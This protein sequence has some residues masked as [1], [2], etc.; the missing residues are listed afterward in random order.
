MRKPTFLRTIFKTVGSLASKLPH[1]S[2]VRNSLIVMSGSALAQV[3]GYA[4]SIII[5]RLYTPAEF[6]V[7]GAFSA[8]LGV[9]A[10]GITLDY[11]LAIML[12]KEKKRRLTIS[13]CCRPWRP[14]GSR[15]SLSLYA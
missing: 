6:G 15:W 8:V 2:F 10:A 14:W 4:L 7:Y 11:S 9:I 13:L 12:P 3:L 5:S 1:S